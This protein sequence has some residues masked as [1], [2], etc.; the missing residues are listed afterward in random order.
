MKTSIKIAVAA[1]VLASFGFEGCK[2]GENDPFLSLSSRKAR[3][4]GEWNVTAGEGSDANSSPASTTTWTY[5][6]A[7]Y[8]QTSGSTTT[9]TDLVVS[10][11]FEKDGTYKTV[12]TTSATGYKYELT[13]SGTWNFTGKI[14]EDKN[15]DHLVMKT[16]VSTE[17]ETLGS[18]TTT[19]TETYTGDDAPTSLMYIDQLKSK[20]MI[21]T[22]DGTTNGGGNNTTTSKGSWTLTAK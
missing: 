5:D 7:T 18:A 3:V 22:Y 13:Q 16:L 19:N 12:S 14:G 11:T 1:L 8:K 20:E 17:V 15:K 4:A 2:K 6:G 21:F 9:S 10:Y